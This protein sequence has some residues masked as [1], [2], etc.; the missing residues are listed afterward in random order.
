MHTD[1]KG[2]SELVLRQGMKGG[3]PGLDLALDG[4]DGVAEVLGD[5]RSHGRADCSGDHLA[6]LLVGSGGLFW[7]GGYGGHGRGLLIYYRGIA[8]REIILSSVFPYQSLI[9]PHSFPTLYTIPS[10]LPPLRSHL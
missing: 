10:F 2:V 3:G 9:I 4:I 5:D 7:L 1:F 6:T 8:S